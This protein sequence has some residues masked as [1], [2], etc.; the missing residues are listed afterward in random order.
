[1]CEYLWYSFFQVRSAGDGGRSYLMVNDVD[2][3]TSYILHGLKQYEHPAIGKTGGHTLPR[4]LD[5]KHHAK[6]AGE[7]LL[8]AEYMDQLQESCTVS[9]PHQNGLVN[10]WSNGVLA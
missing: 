4:D 1:M 7:Q 10:L 3:N 9:P 5:K 2:H 6:I 8:N